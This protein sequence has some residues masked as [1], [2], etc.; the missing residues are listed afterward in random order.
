MPQLVVGIFTTPSK[1][2]RFGGFIFL[3]FLTKM[4]IQSVNWYQVARMAVTLW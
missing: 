3:C 2:G 4:P 1:F